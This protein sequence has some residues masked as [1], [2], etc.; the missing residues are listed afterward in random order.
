VCEIDARIWELPG[1]NVQPQTRY[2]DWFL[3]VSLTRTW[4]IL[5]IHVKLARDASVGIVSRLRV[6][7]P[8]NRG[9]ISSTGMRL[10]SP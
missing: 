10:S 5:G 7:R 2:R 4:K 3:V 9:S 8:R 6:G 1:E